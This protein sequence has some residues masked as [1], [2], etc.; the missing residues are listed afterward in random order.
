MKTF[1]ITII[2]FWY[3]ILS[4]WAQ[5]L[6][7]EMTEEEKAM[8]ST[9]VFPKGKGITTP[10]TFT[11]R[12]MGE[13]EEIEAL[14]IT[15]TSYPSVLA[16][17]VDA[18]QEE[19]TVLIA[20]SDSNSVKNSLTSYGVPLYNVD[21][22][23]VPYNSV[24]IRDYGA[25]T[26]YENEVGNNA[27]VD[28]IYNRPRP[29]DDVMP[30]HHAAW[31][32]LDLY[33]MT[34]SPWDIKATGGNFMV[35]GFGTAM[36]SELILDENPGHNQAEI[37]TIM[38][39]FLGINRYIL[40]PTLPYD[41]IHHIDMHMKFLDEETILVGE[42]PNGISDGPQIEANLAWL[43]SNY[44]SMFG[45]PYRIIRI[46]MPSNYNGTMWPSD[47][48][49]YRT[50]T[51]GVFVNNT[52]IY[53]SY[54]EKYDTTAYRIYKEALPGYN[55]VP[56]NCDPDPISASGAIHCITNSIGAQNPLLIS[57]QRLNDPQTTVGDYQVDA[58]IKHES[59]IASAT[60]Y[61]KTSLT[62][63][64]QSV[65]M[66]NTG[67]N[68]WTGF[69]PAQNSGD[70]VYYYIHAQ[71]VNGK[72]QTRP[73]PAPD[74]YWSFRVDLSA[75]IT[76]DTTPA[77]MMDVYPNPAS[78]ITCIPV[79]CSSEFIGSLQLLDAGGRL[80][81]IIHNGKF[82]AGKSNYFFNALN[83]ESG[84]YF[85]KLVTDEDVQVQKVVVRNF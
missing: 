63:S 85:I 58:Y 65:A 24:W 68:M 46:P 62:G 16:Q 79:N 21:F 60:V 50:Y 23:Q 30:I 82:P 53:P 32:G 51:N 59:G 44:M 22:I 29:D 3:S 33:E 11:P 10:P 19:C 64:Y 73:M 75:G 7:K 72:E 45:T 12:A 42:Y 28:W 31:A 55:L 54:Y 71:A 26:I 43:Q 18:A 34:T 36:S 66:T 4:I 77:T 47:G 67:G 27:L 41:G 80:V 84:I 57:H 6:P 35:D 76:E 74:G 9:Y 17:I 37:D 78:Y 61:Y 39:K 56:I 5:N 49:Y 15:W 1:L 48:A 38:K 8:M 20:C 81:K 40:F 52:Y 83:L 69:I 14:L 70:S 2:V 13:W 25:Y